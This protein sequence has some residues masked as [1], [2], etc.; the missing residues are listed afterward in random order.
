M[1]ARAQRVEVSTLTRKAD[2]ARRRRGQ[3]PSRCAKGLPDASGIKSVRLRLGGQVLNLYPLGDNSVAKT[4]DFEVA[5]RVR[6]LGA[7]L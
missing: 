4:G 5:D 6:I 2:E 3:S 7:G 1:A